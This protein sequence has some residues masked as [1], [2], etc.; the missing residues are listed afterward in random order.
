MIM[1][2]QFYPWTHADLA[3]EIRTKLLLPVDTP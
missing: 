2:Y 3:G 1:G